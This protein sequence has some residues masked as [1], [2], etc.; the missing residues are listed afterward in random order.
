MCTRFGLAAVV[1][2]LLSAASVAAPIRFDFGNGEVDGGTGVAANVEIDEGDDMTNPTSV[3]IG[4]TEITLQ[5]IGPSG[6]VW[7]ATSQG[8]GIIP[9]DM[10]GMGGQRRI[11]GTDGEY[12]HFSFD[13]DAT[14][15]SIR[16]GALNADEQVTIAFVS[17]TD[18]FG[19]SSFTLSYP[20]SPPGPQDDIP[21]G[22]FVTAGTVLSLTAT[23]PVQGGVLWNDVLVTPIPEPATLVMPAFAV[24]AG[25]A[26]RRRW[27]QKCLR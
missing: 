8:I 23:T 1:G 18:P 15:D 9:D 6:R 17:G 20:S 5:G 22:V 7:G 26:F 10:L 12:V 19:G 11:N 27:S 16:L 24:V 21:V 25:I 14:I 3:T 13:K 4:G 2:L